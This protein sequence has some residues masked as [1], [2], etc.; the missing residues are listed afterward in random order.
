[1]KSYTLWLLGL[2]I[3]WLSTGHAQVV[4]N[5]IMYNPPESGADSLEFVEIYNVSSDT[6]SLHQ[7]A[8]SKGVQYT[9]P[10]TAV[11]PQGYLV[12]CINAKA[13]QNVF[14]TSALEWESGALRN[15]GEAIVLVDAQGQ[16]VDSVYY[17]P[18]GNWPALAN[19]QGHSLELCDPTRDNSIASHWKASQTSTQQQ[20]NGKNI[21]A[22]P[23]RKNQVPCAEAVIKVV[24]NAFQPSSLRIKTGWTVEWQNVEGLHNVNGKKSIYP[25]NPVEF[26]SGDPQSGTWRY[27]FRFDTPGIYHYHCDVH[28]SSGMKGIIEVVNDTPPPILLTEIM[29][30][31]PA[32]SDDS[33][34]Y[35]EIYNAGP[36]RINMEGLYFSAGITF[37]FPDTTMPPHAYWVIAKDSK[38]MQNVFGIEAF[39][40][41]E[42]ALSNGGERIELKTALHTVIFSVQYDDED[43]WPPQ[44]DG[45]GYALALCDLQAAHDNPDAWGLNAHNSG[46]VIADRTIYA[47]PGAADTCRTLVDDYPLYR[48]SQLRGVDSV[49]LPDSLDVRCR[50]RGVVYGIDL[51]RGNRIQF[52][53]LDAADRAGIGI[54]G[55]QNFG[56]T[57][58]EG[59]SLE[60]KG[61]VS[62]FNGL[63]QI[64]VEEITVLDS[65]RPLVT[66]RVVTQLDELTES[67][68]IQLR[69]VQLVDSTEWLGNGR[70]FVVRV[71]DGMHQYTVYIDDAV[72]LS[73][74]PP[75]KG[76]FHLTGIGGQFDRESPYFDGYQIVPR[77]AK[78]IE[79]VTRNNLT[80]DV[81]RTPSIVP[82]PASS[83]LWI[84]GLTIEDFP[85]R[86]EVYNPQGMRFLSHVW[87]DKREG[88]QKIPIAHL[89]DGYYLLHLHTARRMRHVLGFVKVGD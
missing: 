19:G 6:L 70:F 20:I 26:Y 64:L 39:Q 35:L 84:Q 22:S 27:A 42:G 11:P 12:V 80:N 32:R 45:E 62:F 65:M 29:Y 52:T 13:F 9:F 74:M 60:V 14:G 85:L 48:I 41:E 40:W 47:R 86:C 5:E 54:F 28:R 30:N 53:L 59:D 72:E 87:K 36:D 73:Q 15:S 49:G 17:Q 55:T 67:D 10:D 2:F 37:R 66:P 79:R 21:Y 68:L 83:H 50:V 75:P 31:P 34:E 56:Y 63:T 1:M 58:R 43:P 82:N 33:L 81:T 3:S 8:F 61:K 57:V 89:K 88:K 18:A 25:D 7:W 71:T 38:A 23:G 77:Y 78:D 76:K 4:I 51:Q 16:T 69:N 44:A 24:N 46:V